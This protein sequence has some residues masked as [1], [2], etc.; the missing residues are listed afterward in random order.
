M[1]CSAG[2]AATRVWGQTTCCVLPCEKPA[3]ARGDSAAGPPR[4]GECSYVG[5]KC[6]SSLRKYNVVI[7]WLGGERFKSINI[8]INIP[9]VSTFLRTHLAPPGDKQ[10]NTPV[11][12]SPSPVPPAPARTVPHEGG[13]IYLSWMAWG[14]S[15]GSEGAII[16]NYQH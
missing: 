14:R 10:V 1:L 4:S 9:F 11:P 8:P 5:L 6:S 3:A 13:S 16:M 7:V 2:T 15:A 12:T